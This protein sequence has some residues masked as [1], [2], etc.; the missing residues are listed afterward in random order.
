[1]NGKWEEEE[2][3]DQFNNNYTC[4]YGHDISEN[5][6]INEECSQCENEWKNYEE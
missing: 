2:Q 3:E 1:M 4:P 6:Y 5:D